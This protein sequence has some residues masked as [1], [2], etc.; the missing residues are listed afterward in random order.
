VGTW[1]AYEL[2]RAVQATGLPL[3]E[4]VFL[5]GEPWQHPWCS[6]IWT[7]IFDTQ[8]YVHHAD[9][10]SGWV[11]GEATRRGM[12]HSGQVCTHITWFATGADKFVTCL[13]AQLP[14]AA[15]ASPD[16]PWDQRPWRQQRGL[17][18]EQFKVRQDGCLAAAAASSVVQP[19]GPTTR[20][21]LHPSD[22]WKQ[23]AG[24]P[25]LGGAARDC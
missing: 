9:A 2:L 7:C 20:W 23:S 8:H 12:Q 16:I 19:V 13:L 25:L 14:A 11:A 10:Q 18:E 22:M 6:I 17:D 21:G 15:M 3:P 4:K 1:V 24:T 5:S